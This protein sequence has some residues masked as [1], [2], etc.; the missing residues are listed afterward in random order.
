METAHCLGGSTTG[1]IHAT[2]RNAGS[3]TIAT[4]NGVLRATWAEQLLSDPRG[5]F[6]RLLGPVTGILACDGAN[7]QALV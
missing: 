2:G 6:I 1:V 7:H 4:K 3:E 5:K